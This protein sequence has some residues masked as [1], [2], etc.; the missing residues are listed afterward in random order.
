VR[1]FVGRVV[2]LLIILFVLGGL[3]FAAAF[4]VVAQAPNPNPP[5]PKDDLAKKI[6][7]L[8]SRLGQLPTDNADLTKALDDL[9]QA[10][11]NNSCDVS[12]A[13]DACLSRLKDTVQKLTEAIDKSLTATPP[14]PGLTADQVKT[15][16]SQI[17]ALAGVIAVGQPPPAAAPSGGTP[18]GTPSPKSTT[19]PPAAPA[20]VNT[21]PDPTAMATEIA[22]LLAGQFND[23]PPKGA[24]ITNKDLIKALQALPIPG[25]AVAAPST[26]PGVIN[27][28]G[29]YFGDLDDIQRD[30]AANR[31]GVVDDGRLIP[32]HV[33]N[34]LW[35]PRYCSATRTMRTYCQGQ[36][37]CFVTTL[38]TTS[39]KAPSSHINGNEMCGFDPIP[40]TEAKFKGLAVYFECLTTDPTSDPSLYSDQPVLYNQVAPRPA[41]IRP[42]ESSG[43]YCSQAA[44]P[45]G[46]S[47][48][49]TTTS[50]GPATF[51]VITGGQNTISAT[52][53]VPTPS[54]ATTPTASNATT[55]Q[56]GSTPNPSPAPAATPS[57]SGGQ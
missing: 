55:T 15:I 38:S 26:P 23:P 34:P 9:S 27:V 7:D 31:I 3:S 5:N 2:R 17:V 1:T 32:I 35:D 49:Q 24:D 19:P 47:A 8:A 51:T 18:Q 29:A 40:Y 36:Q 41:F 6:E 46:Q 52:A 57:P 11:K 54:G 13:A 10:I 22:K 12:S 21:T 43:I 56:T 28:L 44:T 53:P 45:K 16:K 14:K 20:P 50:A 39:D 48:N 33:P 25:K 37:S 30:I 42:G 4:S